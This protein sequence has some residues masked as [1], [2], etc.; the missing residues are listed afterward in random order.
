MRLKF[1]TS[2]GESYHI[3]IDV[4]D[5]DPYWTFSE[6]MFR[7]IKKVQGGHANAIML[8]LMDKDLN[9]IRYA[10]LWATQSGR[11]LT[12]ITES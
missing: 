10:H 5:I 11:V 4:P 6:L 12:Q 1:Q 2:A 9:V 8:Y 3:D 7:L